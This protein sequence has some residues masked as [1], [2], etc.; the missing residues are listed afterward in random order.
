MLQLFNFECFSFRLNFKELPTF[1]VFEMPGRNYSMFCTKTYELTNFSLVFTKKSVCFVGFLC[2]FVVYSLAATHCVDYIKYKKNMQCIAKRHIR[3]SALFRCS[4]LTFGLLTCFSQ[5]DGWDRT[6]Q[7]TSLSMLLLDPF[8]R[9]FEGFQVVQHLSVFALTHH[10]QILIAKEWCSFGHQFARRCGHNEEEK[11]WHS[12]LA[13]IFFQVRRKP[14][15]AVAFWRHLAQWLECVAT[16]LRQ[17]PS[18][19]EFNERLLIF[20]ADETYLCRFG[21]FLCNSQ[22]ERKNEQLSRRTVSIWSFVNDAENRLTVAKCAQ[23]GG[24]V[25][26]RWWLVFQH[27][28][29]AR[30]KREK[31]CERV[32]SGET[33]GI[34]EKLLVA[35]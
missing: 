19:F 1:M 9:T 15:T 28:L 23:N 18:C 20:L 31:Q 14:S 33:S 5:S 10:M 30:K 16:L 35:M 8:Y 4:W 25:D 11:H 34:L 26:A 24:F 21:T 27:F 7:L 12:E 13:P 3:I 2:A 17:D 32:Q 29:L 22:R 6:S